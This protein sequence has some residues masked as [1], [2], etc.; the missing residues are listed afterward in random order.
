MDGFLDVASPL[1]LGA[2]RSR[3]PHVGRIQFREQ[4]S[5]DDLRLLGAAM[6]EF[7]QV[8]LR[9]YGV[10]LADVPDIRRWFPHLRR[11]YLDLHKLTDVSALADRVPELESL[12]IGQTHRPLDLRPVQVSGLRSLSVGTR[13]GT[14]MSGW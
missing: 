8:G 2:V 14:P 13:F 7:P 1:D 5:D 6:G 11:F 4:L 9:V 12:E 3:L 10:S